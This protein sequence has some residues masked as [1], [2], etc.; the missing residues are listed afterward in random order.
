MLMQGDTR[1]SVFRKK[2][3]LIFLALIIKTPRCFYPFFPLDIL[4]SHAHHYAGRRDTISPDSAHS[5]RLCISFFW[6]MHRASYR[7]LLSAQ[8]RPLYC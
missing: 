8:Q 6:D 3:G 5:I 4:K 7:A 1:K 2:E